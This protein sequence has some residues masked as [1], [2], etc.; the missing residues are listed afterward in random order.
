MLRSRDN[1]KLFGLD[2]GAFL[3]WWGTGLASAFPQRVRSAIRGD[4]PR[5]VL[6]DTGQGRVRVKWRD[7][8]G[9][10]SPLGDYARDGTVPSGIKV[11][12]ARHLL[13]LRLDPGR[14]L[15]R[16]IELPRAVGGDL[17][18]AI[19]YQLPRLTPFTADEVF[20]SVVATG[21]DEGR[22]RARLVVVGRDVV[23]EWRRHVESAWGVRPDIVRSVDGPPTENVLASGDRPAQKRSPWPVL[24][25]SMLLLMFVFSLPGIPL[26]QKWQHA[27]AQSDRLEALRDESS[28]TVTQREALDHAAESLDALEAEYGAAPSILLALEEVTRLLPDHTVLDSFEVDGRQLFI[29]G[30]SSDAAA[31]ISIL[32]GSPRLSDVRFTST[33][34]RD[35]RI[36]LERFELKAQL[37]PRVENAGN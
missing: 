14:V 23:E 18:R 28:K 3:H 30:L 11:P 37:P 33:V 34:R 21:A 5:L 27:Q 26:W 15:A 25:L 31:I 13:E 10:E 36:G 9:R 12:L 20:Y 7:A 17:R 22:L 35:P 16:D 1:L 19:R 2:L 24:A 4:V 8:G 29:K 32:E 6:E